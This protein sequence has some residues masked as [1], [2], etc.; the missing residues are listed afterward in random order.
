MTQ[1][2]Y[3]DPEFFERYWK[4]KTSK[5]GQSG[6]PD[7]DT[8]ES[9]L[10]SLKGKSVLDIG[11]G[12]GWFC[13]WARQNGA[14]KTHGID[15]SQTML[16]KAQ[17]SSI[18][19]QVMSFST[20]DLNRPDATLLELAYDFVFSSLTLH[21]LLDLRRTLCSVHDSLQPGG[22]FFFSMEHPMWTAT[23]ERSVMLDEGGN[24]FWP[25]ANYKDEG[26]RVQNWLSEGVVKQHRTLES[27]LG[28]IIEANY[29]IVLFK[30]WGLRDRDHC[31]TPHGVNGK[32][33]YVTE[34]VIPCYLMFG[35]QKRTT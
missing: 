11:C 5:P 17:Q 6:V 30:E 14:K 32:Q 8:L 12:D 24:V 28:A 15:V 31:Q 20:L 18:D 33:W 22:F 29:E 26:Q 25:M 34:D 23:R 7:Y 2:I 16:A 35:L 19:D 3:D 4:M 1:N 13:R 9:L 21:Y 10:P 27:I